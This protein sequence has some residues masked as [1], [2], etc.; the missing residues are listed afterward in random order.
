MTDVEPWPLS[1]VRPR[2]VLT[3]TAP[4][5][6]VLAALAGALE[7][8]GY[9]IGVRD[10]GRLEASRRAW[11]NLVGLAPPSLTRI[12]AQVAVGP[13]GTRLQL[14]HP[15]RE[16]STRVRARST[17]VVRRTV[18]SLRAAGAQVAVGRWESGR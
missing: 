3:T 9:A 11:E 6:G 8:E 1:T 5:E 7:A 15:T 4:P 17:R 2:L 12:A 10:A 14:D 16:L 18:E 13:E